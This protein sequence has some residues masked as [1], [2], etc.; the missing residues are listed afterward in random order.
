MNFQD[1]SEA[2]QLAVLEVRLA[3]M[4]NRGVRV[5]LFLDEKFEYQEIAFRLMQQE[6]LNEQQTATYADPEKKALIEEILHDMYRR[7]VIFTDL[8]EAEAAGRQSRYESVRELAW[9]RL[10]QAVAE[11]TQYEG[12]P[13]V[14][15]LHNCLYGFS[16][17]PLSGVEGSLAVQF[18]NGVQ[19]HYNLP[20]LF[21]SNALIV[22]DMYGERGHTGSI[23]SERGQEMLDRL[24][25][26]HGKC[27]WEVNGPPPEAPAAPTEVPQPL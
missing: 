5:S 22:H 3:A 8:E 11:I 9:S 1:K 7:N 16:L 27:D 25:L 6:S 12:F 21:D 10:D 19:A 4:K 17:G 14:Q 13:T 2:E 23:L 24:D 15:Q 26:I 20:E 18:Q